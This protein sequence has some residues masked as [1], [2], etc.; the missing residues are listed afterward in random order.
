M[1]AFAALLLITGVASCSSDGYETGDG[2]YSYLQADFCKAHVTTAKTVD[3]ILTDGGDSVHLVTPATVG[4]AP[5]KHTMWREFAS[6][7]KRARTVFSSSHLLLA[8][9]LVQLSLHSVSP[10]STTL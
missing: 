1:G 6:Y 2:R 10:A 8:R 7:D 5:S 9:L 4:R 3:Y